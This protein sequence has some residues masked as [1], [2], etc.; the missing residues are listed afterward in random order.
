[1]GVLRSAARGAVVTVVTVVKHRLGLASQAGNCPCCCR[2]TVGGD[3]VPVT[4]LRVGDAIVDE[5][6]DRGVI[7]E[8]DPSWESSD[9]DPE[10]CVNVRWDA[11]TDGEAESW[12]WPTHR[13]SIVSV[14]RAVGS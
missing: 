5:F 13:A 7:V 11:G 14:V 4:E 6:G 12:V 8:W 1:M 2:A 9:V 10:T 3:R